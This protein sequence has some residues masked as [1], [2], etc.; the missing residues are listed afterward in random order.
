MNDIRELQGVI[1]KLHGVE[2]FHVDSVRV[3]EI[4]EGKTVWMGV[5]EVFFPNVY[6]GS[7]LIALIEMTLLGVYLWLAIVSAREHPA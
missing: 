1:R 3:K 7:I 2:S 5:V 6:G 4:F